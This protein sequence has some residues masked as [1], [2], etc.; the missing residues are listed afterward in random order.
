MSEAVDSYFWIHLFYIVD[1]LNKVIMVL[2]WFDRTL[3]LDI[4]C[5]NQ[6]SP[7]KVALLFFLIKLY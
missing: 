3:L 2:F 6:S 4:D 7:T 1:E 5:Y